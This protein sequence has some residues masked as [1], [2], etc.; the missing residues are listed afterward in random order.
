[1]REHFCAYC[2]Q[3]LKLSYRDSR[4]VSMYNG[5]YHR[6]MHEACYQG[7]FHEITL[8]L[9][10]EII[11]DIIHTLPPWK[12]F[13]Q[14]D[15]LIQRILLAEMDINLPRSRNIYG[16]MIRFSLKRLGI[17]PLHIRNN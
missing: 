12:E 4:T 1:M 13:E 8:I 15:D 6:H 11:N 10:L 9:S 17:L 5:R 16:D 14:N 2:K 3:S 7:K